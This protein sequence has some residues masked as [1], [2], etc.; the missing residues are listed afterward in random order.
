MRRLTGAHSR[1][2]ARA[3][4]SRCLP[5]VLSS[6]TISEGSGSQTPSSRVNTPDMLIAEGSRV[7]GVEAA[8][9]GVSVGPGSRPSPAL[10]QA[11]HAFV[12]VHEPWG[13]EE[14]G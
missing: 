14:D 11:D 13:A 10:H 9:P 6:V 5:E 3:R 12:R 4:S 1:P 8:S 2:L 7:A